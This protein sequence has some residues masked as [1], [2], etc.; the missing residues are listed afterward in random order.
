[1]AEWGMEISQLELPICAFESFGLGL[2]LP[3]RLPLASAP[4]PMWRG[5]QP[6]CA[7]WAMAMAPWRLTGGLA[8]GVRLAPMETRLAPGWFRQYLRREHYSIA[9][10]GSTGYYLF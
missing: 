7:S 10:I 2:G 3:A 9:R 6:R 4:R 8:G 1:M 5:E